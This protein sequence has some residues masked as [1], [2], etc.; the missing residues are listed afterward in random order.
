LHRISFTALYSII[1]LLNNR[2]MLYRITLFLSLFL[3]ISCEKETPVVVPSDTSE[4]SITVLTDEFEEEPIV[5]V[6]SQKSDFMVAFK[7]TTSDGILLDFEVEQRQLPIIMK[8]NEGNKWNIEGKAVEGP[9]MGEQLVSIN[10]YLGFWFAWS[11]MYPGLEIYAGAEHSGN[12]SANTPPDD[13]SIATENVFTVL[14]QDGIPA[15]DEPQFETYLER[16]FIEAGTYFIEDDDLVVAITVGNTTK[17]YPHSI[18][19]WHEIVNDAIG[20][21]NYSVSFCPITGTATMW[22]RTING[23]TTTFGVSGLLYNGNVIPYDRATESRWSQMLQ[24]CINGQ[25]IGSEMEIYQVLETKWS[26]AKL[27]YEEPLVMTT[28]TGFG[29]DYTVNPYENYITDNDW[30][31]YPIEHED[32]RLPNKERVLGVIINDKARVYQFKDF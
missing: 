32:S 29:K 30:I 14:G 24:D 5:L 21:F 20:D 28:D 27:L 26:T 2:K 1:R 25:L 12:I 6:G 9:R 10:S 11:T 22:N 17:I 3:F 19:N 15:V 18:L 13:W 4:G 31:S 23:N 8:D 7:R 16:D